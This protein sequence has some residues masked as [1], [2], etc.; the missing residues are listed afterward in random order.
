MEDLS[1]RLLESTGYAILGDLLTIL[2]DSGRLEEYEDK[3]IIEAVEMAPDFF[4]DTFVQKA[5]DRMA[6]ELRRGFEEVDEEDEVAHCYAHGVDPSPG[7]ETCQV[8][9]PEG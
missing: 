9:F 1:K 3:R 8:L 6:Q 7:C 5:L 2:L 4:Y